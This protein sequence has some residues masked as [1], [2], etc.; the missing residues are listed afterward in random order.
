M[1][2]IG[3]YVIEDYDY[4]YE[5]AR[6]NGNPTCNIKLFTALK[7]VKTLESAYSQALG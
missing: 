4:D 2:W 3:D 5:F 1:S 6:Q 7:R